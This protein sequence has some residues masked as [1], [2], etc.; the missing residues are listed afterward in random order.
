M[1][2]LLIQIMTGFWHIVMKKDD[3]FPNFLKFSCGQLGQIMTL[4][5]MREYQF[6]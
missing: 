2:G 1:Y 4:L 3:L 6:F 5:M